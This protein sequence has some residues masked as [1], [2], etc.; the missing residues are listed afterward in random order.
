MVPALSRVWERGAWLAANA[1]QQ[2]NQSTQAVPQ[3][4]QGLSGGP[5][6]DAVEERVKITKVLI[7]RMNPTP[8][9]IR[10][11]MPAK[12]HRR[13]RK[14]L[15]SQDFGRR[16]VTAAMFD[17]AVDQQ[18]LG[19]RFAAGKPRRSKR[20]RPSEAEKNSSTT[21]GF[22]SF[23]SISTRPNYSVIC[24]KPPSPPAPLPSTGEGSC[25]R[26]R[27]NAPKLC[28]KTTI[29]WH[30]PGR[31]KSYHRTLLSRH[32]TRSAGRWWLERLQSRR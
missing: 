6:D 14:A 26:A 32:A 24:S 18:H 10:L 28:D 21:R 29:K 27:T 20:R 8:R 30:V 15:A 1:P 2:S 11:A 25:S 23:A 7:E 12:V 5:A 13:N 4:E 31:T 16:R 3:H 22:M 17:E 9:A 19:P